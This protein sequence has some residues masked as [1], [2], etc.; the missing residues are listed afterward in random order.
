[1]MIAYV[2]SVMNNNNHIVTQLLNFLI[3]FRYSVVD[4][5]NGLNV[6]TL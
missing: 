3:W 2:I 4:R 1:M 6:S 5:S